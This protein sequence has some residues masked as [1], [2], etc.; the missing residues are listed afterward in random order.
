MKRQGE[1]ESGGALAEG[2]A[3]GQAARFGSE[4]ERAF[5]GWLDEEEERLTR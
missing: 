3:G 4:T 5:L 1:I 2:W